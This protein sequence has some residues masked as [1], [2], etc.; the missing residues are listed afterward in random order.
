MDGTEELLSKVLANPK[1]FILFT[2]SSSLRS[3][4]RLALSLGSLCYFLVTP[5]L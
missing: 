5:I 3:P 1:E 2:H 4:T